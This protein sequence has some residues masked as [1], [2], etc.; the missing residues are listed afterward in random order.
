MIAFTV[1]LFSKNTKYTKSPDITTVQILSVKI[2]LILGICL[3]I[4]GCFGALFMSIRYHWIIY[5]VGES[6]TI[7]CFTKYPSCGWMCYICLCCRRSIRLKFNVTKLYHKTNSTAAALILSSQQMK[8]GSEGLAGGGIYF[9]KKPPS[10]EGKA[11]FAPNDDSIMLK[12]TVHLGKIW[13]VGI[14]GEPIARHTSCDVMQQT[15]EER[16]YD[17]V[18]IPRERPEFIVY[19]TDQVEDIRQV[20]Y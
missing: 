14:N 16:E 9:A 11:R 1:D 20:K 6:S 17:S 18:W 4:F 13:K 8:A 3:D 19:N 2:C 7:C 12:A 10:T 5:R 15:L